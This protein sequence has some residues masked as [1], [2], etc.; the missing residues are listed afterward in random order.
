M[1]ER[2]KK[3]KERERK[4]E[5][6]RKTRKRN[7]RI[8]YHITVYMDCCSVRIEHLIEPKNVVQCSVV[9]CSAV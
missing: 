4:N 8:F 3:K 9:Q 7:N 2:Q 5:R 1:R 6:E